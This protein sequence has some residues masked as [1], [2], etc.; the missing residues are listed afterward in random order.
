M[1]PARHIYGKK[2]S[3]TNSTSVEEHTN[4][5]KQV[6]KK[7]VTKFLLYIDTPTAAGVQCPLL[8]IFAGVIRPLSWQ[9]GYP[10]VHCRVQTARASGFVLNSSLNL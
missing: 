1:S 4:S 9:G 8:P 3:K 10:H 5:Q 6:S 7:Y 2:W